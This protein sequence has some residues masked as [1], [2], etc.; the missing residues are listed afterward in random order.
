[1]VTP[2]ESANDEATGFSLERRAESFGYAFA[3]VGHLLH[4]QHNAW[5]HLVFT[6]AVIGVG[7]LLPLSW[8][9]WA[10]LVLAMGLVWTAEALNTAIEALADAV[11]VDHHPLVGRA[12]DVAAGAVLLS[13]IAS[14]LVGLLVLGPHLWVWITS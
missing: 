6:I 7:V 12:K 9:E 14:V 2:E 4:T 8:L 13:A 1:M 10:A 5:I 3:G 11:S